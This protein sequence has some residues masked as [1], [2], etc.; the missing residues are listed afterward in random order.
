[1]RKIF[2]FILVFTQSLYCQ[3]QNISHFA[4]SISK[5][6]VLQ[7]DVFTVDLE[8]TND[9]LKGI[10][11][12][13]ELVS[14]TKKKQ[15]YKYLA[16]G[17][18]SLS[19]FHSNAM[20]KE[21]Y[22]DSMLFYS[23]MSKV[24]SLLTDSYYAKANVEYYKGNYEKAMEYLSLSYKSAIIDENDTDEFHVSTRM[25]SIKNILQRY[26]EAHSIYKNAYN[27]YSKEDFNRL[28]TKDYYLDVI[29]NLTLTFSYLK[30]YDST[31]LYA[32]KGKHLLSFYKSEEYQNSFTRSEAIGYL[33]NGDYSQAIR[34]FKNTMKGLSKHD[35]A[36]SRY[37]IGTAYKLQGNKEEAIK[38]YAKADSILSITKASPFPDMKD[39]YKFAFNHY[40]GKN[41]KIATNYLEKYF[42]LDS[43]LETRQSA[44]S[45]RLHNLY[46]LPKLKIESHKIVSEKKRNR[47]LTIFLIMSLIGAVIFIRYQKKL[48]SKQKQRIEELWSS[49]S[50]RTSDTN[51]SFQALGNVDNHLDIKDDVKRKLLLDL[52]DFEKNKGYLNNSLTLSSLSKEL[53]TN[54]TY[55]SSIINTSKEMN[56]STY[57]KTLRINNAIQI[58]IS[59]T[60]YR[61]YSM[62]GLAD[63]FGFNNADSF[64][65]AFKE[66]SKINPSLFI[67]EMEKKKKHP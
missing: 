38:N 65:K 18:Y 10:I 15:D 51:L 3:G 34:L 45:E 2:L 31:L 4:D 29:Y 53:D 41:D 54:S 56:F 57:L 19:S 36:H 21:K 40:K 28:N 50:E 6:S 63:E 35:L 44:I 22:V 37:Y 16:R 13:K 62:N 12:S 30:Q 47:Y 9:T 67:K 61:K 49:N 64:S 33:G 43:L 1:M 52:S 23:Q 26:N 24:N 60:D 58:L 7:L 27:N 59:N 55:L 42:K 8:N 39:A 66:I 14:K 46:N 25:A 11:V 20:L 17:Y 5:L 32:K 48:V